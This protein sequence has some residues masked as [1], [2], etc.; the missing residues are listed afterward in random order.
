MTWESLSGKK[1]GCVGRWKEWFNSY[2]V[3]M[4]GCPGV[5]VHL[6]NNWSSYPVQTS[7]RSSIMD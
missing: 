6:M 4:Q 3:N 2:V 1:L 5:N 7:S